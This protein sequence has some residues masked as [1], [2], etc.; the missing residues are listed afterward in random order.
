MLESDF[1]LGWK[2]IYK[3]DYVGYSY[4]YKPRD[5]SVGTTN[6]AGGHNVQILVLSAD[7][8]V[9]HALPGFWHPDDLAR[10]L[11]FA[12]VLARLWDDQD[13]S[14]DEKRDMY[15]RLQMR[16]ISN[17]PPETF[18][19][20]RWQGFDRQA[21]TLRHAK[22]PRDTFFDLAKDGRIGIKP[23]NYLVHERMAQRPFVK[24]KDFDVDAFVDYGR[25]FYDLNHRVDGRGK[26]FRSLRKIK[27]IRAKQSRNDARREARLAKRRRSKH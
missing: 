22:S 26:E 16:E 23:I 27:R 21:E 19:R 25:L 24:L 10:E 18:A 15:R 20:S 6:G 14:I 9:L 2:N 11:R 12:K 1:V 13:R 4:G 17:H 3:Q 8:T 7:L 5:S